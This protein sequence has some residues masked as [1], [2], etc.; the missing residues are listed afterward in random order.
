[1]ARG[2]AEMSQSFTGALLWGTV[3]LLTKEMAESRL[4]GFLNL[5]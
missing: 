3:V 4:K 5:Q 2:E 1:M